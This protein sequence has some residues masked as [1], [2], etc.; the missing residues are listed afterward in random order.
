MIMAQNTFLFVLLIH[1]GRAVRLD[2][3]HFEDM[4]EKVEIDRLGPQGVPDINDMKETFAKGKAAIAATSCELIKEKMIYQMGFLG[5]VLETTCS[6]SGGCNYSAAVTQEAILDGQHSITSL[7]AAADQKKCLPFVLDS[8]MMQEKFDKVLSFVPQVFKA[9]ETPLALARAQEAYLQLVSFQQGI[10]ALADGLADRTLLL[11][12]AIENHCPS[13]CQKCD[14]H[15]AGGFGFRCLL[16]RSDKNKAPQVHMQHRVTCKD[17]TYRWWAW[18]SLYPYARQ[19][20]VADWKESAVQHEHV[21]AMLTCATTTILMGLDGELPQARR[22]KMFDICTKQQQGNKLT[23][24]EKRDYDAQVLVVDG[25]VPKSFMAVYGSI[26]VLG[27]V[28]GLAALRAETRGNERP[29]LLEGGQPTHRLQGILTFFARYLVDE[30]IEVR[31]ADR[32]MYAS[33][34]FYD[35]KETEYRLELCQDVYNVKSQSALIEGT[36]PLLNLAVDQASI[37]GGWEWFRLFLASGVAVIVSY[38]L[39]IALAVGTWS[40]AMFLAP[41]ANMSFLGLVLAQGLLVGTLIGS[42][43]LIGWGVFKL[44]KVIAPA[45]GREARYRFGQCIAELNT[46]VAVASD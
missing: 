26:H 46:T 21:S 41:L 35:R 15:D 36:T 8:P 39:L 14:H 22:H 9:I 30:G 25:A 3:E 27:L 42:V 33:R 43:G 13:P 32:S 19:C 11:T 6:G 44:F 18:H 20:T 12:L 28:S 37:S 10:V 29:V 24:Q 7:A 2:D 1:C 31:E 34:D 23:P 4:D 40:F 45:V 16:W 17:P 38:F 5:Q